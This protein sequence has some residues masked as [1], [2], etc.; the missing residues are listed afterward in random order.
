M[1]NKF[2]CWIEKEFEDKFIKF[3][4]TPVGILEDNIGIF[5]KDIIK[6]NIEKI[7]SENESE[8]FIKEFNENTYNDGYVWIECEEIEE[9][10]GINDLSGSPI[11]EG[12]FITNSAREGDDNLMLVVWDD[13]MCAFMKEHSLGSKSYFGEQINDNIT[14]VGNFHQNKELISIWR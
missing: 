11:F 5:N 7:L 8:L 12:D 9:C 4:A 10:I 13:D 3:Y 14:I 1:R 2:R 6:K